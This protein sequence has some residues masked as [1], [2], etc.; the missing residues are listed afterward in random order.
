MGCLG[1]GRGNYPLFNN[2]FLFNN[3]SH[4]FLKNMVINFLRQGLSSPYLSRI[5]SSKVICKKDLTFLNFSYAIKLCLK[6]H[7]SKSEGHGWTP[8]S[9]YPSNLQRLALP[10][11]HYL[12]FCLEKK[13]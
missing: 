1:G 3:I 13:S 12:D 9:S 8:S 4:T 5:I 6:G 11:I 10:L 2:T 7:V